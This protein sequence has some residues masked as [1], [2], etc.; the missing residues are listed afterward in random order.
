MENLNKQTFYGILYYLP[1]F[2]FG[3]GIYNIIECLYRGYTHISMFFAGGLCLFFIAL[4]DSENPRL[5]LFLKLLLCPLIITATE[6]AFGLVLN[7]GL[8]LTVWDYSNMRF[9]FLGQICPRASFYWL[10][11]SVPALAVTRFWK[12]ISGNIVSSLRSFRE[13]LSQ[14]TPL[15]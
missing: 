15:K 6:L 7:V 2:L 11:L 12:K 9:N 5:P 13:R 8:G 10:L 14:N 4:L 3:G 1:L